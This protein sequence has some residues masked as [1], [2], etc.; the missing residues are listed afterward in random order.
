[1]SLWYPAQKK[2]RKKEKVDW[3]GWPKRLRLV[4]A[5]HWADFTAIGAQLWSTMTAIFVCVALSWSDC[6]FLRIIPDPKS[7]TIWIW[8]QLLWAFGHFAPQQTILGSK[9][10]TTMVFFHPILGT[11][12]RGP[13]RSIEPQWCRH[14]CNFVKRNWANL[15]P[16]A[17][18]CAKQNWSK[19]CSLRQAF[20]GLLSTLLVAS[21]CPVWL[22]RISR[23]GRVF[24]L[25]QWFYKK[26]RFV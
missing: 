13:V 20:C 11:A 19:L 4:M 8:V 2:S 16:N 6:S 12:S 14:D 7:K 3:A 21:S 25:S 10:C 24:P 26:A 1:M 5:T 17:L 9:E 18:H 15:I 23:K 22:S